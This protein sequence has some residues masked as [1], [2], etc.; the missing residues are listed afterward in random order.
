MK[1]RRIIDSWNRVEIDGTADQRVLDAV[2]AENSLKTVKRGAFPMNK[3]KY[4]G[5]A[6]ALA[7]VLLISGLAAGAVFAEDIKA[8]VSTVL[9]LG[10]GST[11]PISE[12]APVKIKDTAVISADFISMS[13]GEAEEML[14]IKLLTT[15]RATTSV[16]H[17]RTGLSQGRIGRV[18]LWRPGFIDFGGNDEKRI[19][20]S[21]DFLTPEAG[22]EYIDPFMEGIDA[23]GQKEVLGTYPF[24]LLGEVVLYG[25]SWDD[26]RL[27]ATFVYSDM[28]YTITAN[29]LSQEEMLEIVESLR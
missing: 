11:Y 8:L 9:S 16:V 22:R 20:M 15:D 10:G 17:Y 6:Y 2:L 25:N 14:G 13:V 23:S 3:R 19:S 7:A 27:T 12:I 5:L 24:E 18:D 28:L 29:N 1:N 4:L 26:T 21:V